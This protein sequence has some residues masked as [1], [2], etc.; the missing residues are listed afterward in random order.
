MVAVDEPTTPQ[1]GREY[2]LV[3]DSREPEDTVRILKML[4]GKDVPIHREALDCGDYVL[5]DRQGQMLGIERKTPGDF[6]G[7][8]TDGRLESQLAR[9]HAKYDIR[10]LLLHGA[11]EEGGDGKVVTG[12]TWSKKHT[13]FSYAAFQA[14]LLSV[15]T[16]YDCRLLVV[17]SD[18][19]F[20]AVL[21][22]L[23][24]Q[25]VKEGKFHA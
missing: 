15:Q 19:E 2:P 23:F 13:E 3:I 10:I 14:K 12:S 9:M 6:M 4:L 17:R 16:K 11:Y 5:V 7:S 1:P 20:A 8:I 21:K 18:A 22:T 24:R 25:G